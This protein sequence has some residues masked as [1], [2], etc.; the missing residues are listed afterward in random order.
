LDQ[1]LVTRRFIELARKLRDDA[2]KARET[3]HNDLSRLA[4]RLK[5]LKDAVPKPRHTD[6][7]S[8]DHPHV[9]IAE[10][11]T[12]GPIRVQTE[13][14]RGKVETWWRRIKSG[15]EALGIVA[16][17]FY[18]VFA[19]QQWQ[20]MRQANDVAM[21]NF[22]DAR[23][24]A[25]GQL[26][27]AMAQTEEAT[28][29]FRADQRAW[30]GVVIAKTTGS[31]IPVTLLYHFKNHGKSPATDVV[32]TDNAHVY[33]ERF[34]S[35]PFYEKKMTSPEMDSKATVFPGQENEL[36]GTAYICQKDI[37]KINAGTKWCYT[38]G[39][40]TYK[41]E[42]GIKHTTHF[43]FRHGKPSNNALC[44]TYNDAD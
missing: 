28:R 20:A 12:S 43:C 32:I 18:T 17:I 10:L 39:I 13:K 33:G 1:N 3:L 16:V 30:V 42:F 31:P 27:Q 6:V 14:N 15:L 19:Y 23:I 44:D 34:P 38:Y 4:D 35:S 24:Y 22:R 25:N 40:I 8:V 9:T 2:R 7:G 21:G 41:D 36:D 5:D 29:N 26:K 11:R 37:G